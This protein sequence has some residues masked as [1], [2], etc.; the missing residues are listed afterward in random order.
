MAWLPP[1]PVERL[2]ALL[3]AA[4][5]HLVVQK[6]DAADLM[7]PSKLTNILAAGR[8]AI[9]TSAPNTALWDVLEEGGAGRCVAP[10]SPGALVAGLCALADDAGLRAAMGVRARRYAEVH[11]ARDV[12]L[13]RFEHQL[14]ALIAGEYPVREVAE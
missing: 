1:Q 3:S 12:I 13:A 8:A 4:D 6:R 10:E 5:I 14:E 9:A 2:S 7:M 11:L